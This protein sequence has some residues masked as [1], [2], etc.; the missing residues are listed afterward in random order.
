MVLRVVFGSDPSGFRSN[1]TPA[2]VVLATLRTARVE[3]VLEKHH[4]SPVT[5]VGQV[6][7]GLIAMASNP[8]AVATVLYV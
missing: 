5:A 7:R 3:G 4:G 8:L 6:K 1:E 2:R